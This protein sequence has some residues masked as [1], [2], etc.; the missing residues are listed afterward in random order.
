MFQPAFGCAQPLKAG[1]NTQL[2]ISKKFKQWF[3]ELRKYTKLHI[4]YEFRQPGT[5]MG[6]RSG[7]HIKLLLLRPSRYCGR[8]VLI[9]NLQKFTIQKCNFM[10][11]IDKCRNRRNCCRNRRALLLR[12]RNRRA[13]IENSTQLCSSRQKVKNIFLLCLFYCGCRSRKLL[14]RP[15]AAATGAAPVRISAQ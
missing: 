2:L 13:A 10:A 6:T 14:Q 4:F 8:D 11:A 1:R 7:G 12:R 5:R 9:R 3:L 15:Q